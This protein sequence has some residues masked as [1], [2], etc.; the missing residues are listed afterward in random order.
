MLILN[1]NIMVQIG[2]RPRILKW[3]KT[4]RE[5]ERERERERIIYALLYMNR[6]C[7]NFELK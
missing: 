4:N 1:A 7:A 2:T 3:Y 6:H 5:R